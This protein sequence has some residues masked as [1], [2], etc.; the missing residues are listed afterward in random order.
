ML[1]T[2]VLVLTAGAFVFARTLAIA[3]FYDSYHP[4]NPAGEARAHSLPNYHGYFIAWVVALGL[5][6]ALAVTQIIPSFRGLPGVR[7]G[8]LIGVGLAGLALSYRIT[9][10]SF[11]ARDHV[12]TFV[13]GALML[14]SGAAILTTFGI[15]LSLLFESFR[16]FE[17]VSP[18]EFLTGLKW[19]PQSG[20]PLEGADGP[21]GF[22]ILPVIAGTFMITLIAMIIAVPIGLFIAIYLSE[23]APVRV[24]GII[25]PLVEILAGIPTVVYGFFALLTVGPAMRSFADMLGF[26]VSAQSAIAVGSVMGVM[27]IPYISSLSDDVLTAVPQ[28]LRNGSYAL[29][30]TKSETVRKVLFPAALP[31]IMGAILLGISRAI[32]ET[33]IVVMAAGHAANLSGNPFETTTTVTVQIVALLTGDQGFD[34]AKTL[35]AYALGLT[36]FAITLLLNIIAL[37][38]VR[39]YRLRFT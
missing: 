1:M 36:L 2:M 27:I 34:S 11:R 35:A 16:F 5:L 29:G 26:D 33:M 24:R 12:E 38:I 8:V 32:G 17:Q 25:K 22:G 37:L 14:C 31:G 28:S 21:G 4:D 3:R 23:Y 9:Q 39:R 6:A 7:G 20:L 30:A 18:F 15:I 13:R 19:S 10:R